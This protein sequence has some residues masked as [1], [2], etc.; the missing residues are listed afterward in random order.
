M[1]PIQC[2]KSYTACPC[3][4]CILPLT[5]THNN[6]YHINEIHQQ[7]RQTKGSVLVGGATQDCLNVITQC[8]SGSG[9][10]LHCTS[11][12][13]MFSCSHQMN[14][15]NFKTHV[16]LALSY[17]KGDMLCM[18]FRYKGLQHLRRRECAHWGRWRSQS[19]W[20]QC[21]YLTSHDCTRTLEYVIYGH[22]I[23]LQY[24]TCKFLIFSLDIC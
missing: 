13:E 18:T 3:T 2:I 1:N 20:H 15:I 5:I 19:F 23:C 6:M 17:L 14:L 12:W 21:I 7:I 4:Y 9:E 16:S 11:P 10:T 8:S 24:I 22:V